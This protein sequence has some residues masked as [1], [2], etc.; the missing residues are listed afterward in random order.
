[1]RALR[2]ARSLRAI[3]LFL[4][5]FA[6]FRLF[7]DL[8]CRP[9]LR[10]VALL[11]PFESFVRVAPIGRR[12][13]LMLFVPKKLFVGAGIHERGAVADLDDL[14]REPLDEVPIVRHEDQRAAVVDERVEEY[15]LR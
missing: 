9:L 3:L 13:A 2:L 6:G 10:A 8:R 7:S 12:L 14:R 5:G 1:M 4:F 15:F 11:A